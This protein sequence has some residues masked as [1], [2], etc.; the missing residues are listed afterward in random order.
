[1]KAIDIFLALLVVYFLSYL[2]V[3]FAFS[4]SGMTKFVTPSVIKYNVIGMF[5]PAAAIDWRITGRQFA[6]Y[7][8]GGRMMIV[9]A[10]DG[11]P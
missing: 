5:Y 3:R 7:G 9:A 8:P 11:R 2:A 6:V 1:M 10:I 4:Q